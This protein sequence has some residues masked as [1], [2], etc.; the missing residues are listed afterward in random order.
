V[1]TSD[2]DFPLPE[3][4]IAQQPAAA[5]DQS[6]LLVL[7]RETGKVTHRQ[8]TDF[9]SF[10]KPGDVLVLNNSRVIPARLRG[11][12]GPGGGDLEVLLLSEVDVNDWWVMVKPGRRARIGTTISFRRRSGEGSPAQAQVIDINPEGHRR[13][14]FSGI[15]NIADVLDSLGE[16]PLPPYIRRDGASDLASDQERYQ[17]VYAEAP[18][19]VAAPTAGL[20][21][22]PEVLHLIRELGV[23]VCFVTLHVGLATFGPVKAELLEEHVMHEERFSVNEE[24]AQAVNAAKREGRRVIAIGTTSVRVLETLAGRHG[25][26][27]PGSDQTR[28]FLRPPHRF[29]M[30]DALLT[31]FHLP[32]STLFMLVSA[33]AAPGEIRGQRMMLETYAEAVRE[34]YRFFSYGDAMFIE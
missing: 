34:L 19:S 7:R 28:L 10:L 3:E 27:R 20:H 14:R 9:P 2:F 31:N 26:I 6:R 25:E 29:Q 24:A 23:Q 8:F 22:T 11:F 5:R 4:L 17:T 33:F 13:L 21:F 18:G 30:V 1:R 12:A 32:R 15:P 16:V